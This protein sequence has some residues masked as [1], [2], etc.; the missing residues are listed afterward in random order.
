MWS[1]TCQ[2]F[3]AVLVDLIKNKPKLVCLQARLAQ[4]VTAAVIQPANPA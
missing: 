4:I 1:K 2:L 3:P